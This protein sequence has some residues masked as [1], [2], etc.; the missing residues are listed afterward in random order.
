[1]VLNILLILLILLLLALLVLL[2]LPVSL[3]IN[4]EDGEFRLWIRY[5]SR[6]WTVFPSKTKEKQETD[7]SKTTDKPEKQKKETTAKKSKPNWDQIT[8]SLDVLPSILLRAL[9]RTARRIR[10][11]PLKIHLLIALG[12]PADTAVLYGKLHGVFNAIL[13]ALHCAVRID[14]QDIQLFPDFTQEEM[15]C[16]ADIGFR[17]RPMDILMVAIMALGGIVRWYKGYKERADKPDSAQIQ[18][19][20]STAQADPAA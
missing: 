2:L 3:R 15:D 4:Y 9:G 14:E 18:E 17:I 13:P 12:D 6:T 8:Y 10:V 7:S 11:S 19:K 16:I 20:K 1:M 5:A